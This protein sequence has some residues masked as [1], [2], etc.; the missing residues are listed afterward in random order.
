MHLIHHLRN[1]SSYVKIMA[2]NDDITPKIHQ[3]LDEA[4]ES[5]MSAKEILTIV[6]ERLL[7]VID[8]Y[9]DLDA[10]TSHLATSDFI[11]GGLETMGTTA[12]LVDDSKPFKIFH[13][14]VKL[15]EAPRKIYRRLT[16]PSNLRLGHLAHIIM[17]AMGWENAHLFMFSKGGVNYEPV[18]D[19][20]FDLDDGVFARTEDDMAF[21]V[22]DVLKEKSDTM[23][24]VY[25]FGDNWEHTVRLS[26]VEEPAEGQ[27]QVPITLDSGKGEC[28]PEDCG[29]VYGYAE[30]LNLLT[31]KR[32][33]SEEK[34]FL[35]WSGLE[36][37][38]DPNG[39]DLH[40]LRESLEDYIGL[41]TNK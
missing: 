13:L 39:C 12:S 38:F 18:T 26:S 21:S 15:D 10:D 23:T 6:M 34:E 36:K 11:P 20:D 3:L 30:L 32:K 2:K 33:T 24:F 16:V 1:F 40:Y 31:K 25:D 17:E 19:D 9:D 27:A 14:Y 37:D 35:E 5:G 7:Q 41:V 22:G 4:I 28:P 29:G 8:F